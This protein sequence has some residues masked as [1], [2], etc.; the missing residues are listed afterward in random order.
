MLTLL[1]THKLSKFLIFLLL[2]NFINLSANFYQVSKTNAS[3][4]SNTDPLDSLAE[5]VLEYFMEMEDQ[6]IPDT[7]VPSEE[8]SLLEIKLVE[9]AKKW[10]YQLH[11]INV[12]TQHGFYFT[13]SFQIFQPDVVSPPPKFTV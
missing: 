11:P 1:K 13:D 6:T 7:D 2:I 3:L 4:Y 9:P 10:I 12:L 5:M 8:R